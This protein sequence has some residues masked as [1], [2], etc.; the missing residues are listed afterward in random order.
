MNDSEVRFK[1]GSKVR[2]HD[3]SDRDPS[4][5]AC[6]VEGVLEGYAQRPDCERYVIKVHRA[7]WDGHDDPF[8]SRIGAEVY[9]PMNGTPVLGPRGGV[10]N[11][12]ELAT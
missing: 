2:S 8:D 9:P 3:F 12:V 7:V 10:I 4:R 1:V 11:N 5:P 6:Y